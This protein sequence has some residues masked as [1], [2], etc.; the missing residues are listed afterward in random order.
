MDGLTHFKLLLH[1]L[2]Y[3]RRHGQECGFGRNGDM[4]ILLSSRDCQI[5][6][7]ILLMLINLGL[8]FGVKECETWQSVKQSKNCL[9]V[10]VV[11]NMGSSE[12]LATHKRKKIVPP[13]FISLHPFLMGEVLEHFQ[14]FSIIYNF[15]AQQIEAP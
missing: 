15:P 10:L 4:E 1:C 9:N 7:Q 3:H 11:A 12:K 8:F 13:I 5:R 2:Q 14:T 6:T